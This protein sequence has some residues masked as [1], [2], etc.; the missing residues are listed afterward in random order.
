MMKI[1]VSGYIRKILEEKL[2]A[3]ALKITAKKRGS[4]LEIA[5]VAIPFG[6]KDVAKNFDAYFEESLK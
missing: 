4:P 5:K 3:K 6:K 1:S 2:Y